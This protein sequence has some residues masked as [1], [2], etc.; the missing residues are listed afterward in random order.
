M[1]QRLATAAVGIPI[2]LFFIWAGG[3]LFIGLV[4]AITAFAAF[5]LSRMASSWGDRVSVAFSALA[6]TALILSAIF[7]EP[8]GDFGRII[9]FS[10]T[11]YAL[12]SA[13]YLLIAV[14]AGLLR[15]RVV[16]TLAVVGFVGGTM[17]HG[18]MIRGLEDGMA[19]IIVVLCVTFST[20]TG[21]LILGRAFGSRK[22]AP[23]ISPEKTWEGA[24]GGLAVGIIVCLVAVELLALD[25]SIVGA[26]LLGTAL[27][28]TGQLGDLAE[29]QLKRQ[30]GTKDSSSLVPGHGGVLD[31]IDSVVWN[32]VVVYHFVS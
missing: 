9:G 27:A 29:S 24:V 28:I 23:N 32:L 3:I 7:Y 4:A 5:E 1:A 6:T 15:L 18:T 31:R 14:P 2:L 26:V 20:D 12:V 17:A 11:G 16:S 21:A 13:A 22:L 25:V 8:D 30:A 10:A 19:W